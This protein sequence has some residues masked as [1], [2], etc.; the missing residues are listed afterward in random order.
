MDT[1]TDLQALGLNLPS[2][3]YLAGS[4]G[5]GFAG[6]LAWRNGK[7]TERRR[8]KWLGLALMVFPYGV[9]STLWLY[10]VGAGLC[11]GIYFSRNGDQV[12][13]KP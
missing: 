8:I 6:W 10:L 7:A 5:F 4:V 3:A 11:C 9:A 2:P 13:N 12:D 1:L